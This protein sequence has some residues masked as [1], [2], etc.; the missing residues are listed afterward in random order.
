[1]DMTDDMK[2]DKGEKVLTEDEKTEEE[3]L[4]IP[5]EKVE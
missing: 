2:D 1:M 3:V 4:D 5:E